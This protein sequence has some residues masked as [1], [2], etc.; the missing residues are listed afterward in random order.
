MAHEAVLCDVIGFIFPIGGI[1]KFQN[2]LVRECKADGK[3]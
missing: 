2:R 3:V 1:Y